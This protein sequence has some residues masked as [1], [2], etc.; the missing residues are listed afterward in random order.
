MA[1]KRQQF[2]PTSTIFHFRKIV[3]RHRI[4]N[5]SNWKSACV[6]AQIL[7]IWSHTNSKSFYKKSRESVKLSSQPQGSEIYYGQ[8]SIPIK[9]LLSC[10][11]QYFYFISSFSSRIW[12]NR[13]LATQ[14]NKYTNDVYHQGTLD[15]T[16]LGWENSEYYSGEEGGHQCWAGDRSVNG[17]CLLSSVRV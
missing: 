3:W 8:S 10:C 13:I 2:P 7:R 14:C 9:I 12:M 11:I 5:W 4:R 6:K 17:A 15:D 1:G 16:P